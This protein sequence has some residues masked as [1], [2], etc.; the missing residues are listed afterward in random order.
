LQMWGR[1]VPGTTENTIV[2]IFGTPLSFGFS[3][4]LVTGTM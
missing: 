3:A 2:A 1:H 4:D